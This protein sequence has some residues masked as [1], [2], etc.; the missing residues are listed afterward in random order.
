MGTRAYAIADL[1]LDHP[2]VAKLR[3]YGSVFEHDKMV[4]DAI[5]ATVNPTDHLYLLGD[6]VIGNAG[7]EIIKGIVCRNIILVPGN[8]CGERSRIQH[9]IFKRVI[10]SYARELPR[11]KIGAVFTHLPVHPDCLDRWTVNVHGHLHEQSIT[12]GRY[13]C[14]SAEQLNYR[15]IC[16]VTITEIFLSRGIHGKD[17]TP[18]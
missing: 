3:G 1:H 7:W 18:L 10:G 12:D 14:V 15:P 11:S 8:H 5:N 2:N 6:I 17:K 13:L 9:D 4:I 16:M